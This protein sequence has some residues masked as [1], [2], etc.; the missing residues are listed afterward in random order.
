MRRPSLSCQ[1][2]WVPGSRAGRAP[3]PEDG[4]RPAPAPAGHCGHAEPL[5][6]T[7]GR[8]T[9]GYLVPFAA[10]VAL[11]DARFQPAPQ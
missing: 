6:G 9:R 11:R 3:R 8:Y 7:A 10:S 5:G 1:V 4:D 2:G